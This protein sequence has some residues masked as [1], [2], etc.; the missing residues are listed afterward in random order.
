M[1]KDVSLANTLVLDTAEPLCQERNIMILQQRTGLVGQES[2]SMTVVNILMVVPRMHL[3]I[4][5]MER[6]VLV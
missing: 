6:R 4:Q 1:P 2:M 3:E 5:N